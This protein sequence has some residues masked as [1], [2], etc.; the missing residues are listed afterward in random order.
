MTTSIDIV[1]EIIAS[2]GSLD[3]VIATAANG[4]AAEDKA[5]IRE[6]CEGTTIDADDVAADLLATCREIEIDQC[7][8]G[9]AIRSQFV[10]VGGNHS[11]LNGAEWYQFGRGWVPASNE[12]T[13]FD[14]RDDAEAAI[15]AAQIA[16][17]ACVVSVTV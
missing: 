15:Q 3:S 12:A 5:T 7:G 1:D 9:F 17:S 8:G 11:T 10:G 6:M 14:S 2:W 16:G 13:L 4:V